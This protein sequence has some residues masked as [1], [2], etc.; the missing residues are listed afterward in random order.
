MTPR[1]KTKIA[2]D[3]N[4]MSILGVQI[5]FVSGFPPRR[6]HRDRLLALATGRGGD[7]RL[8]ARR[9]HRQLA[10]AQQAQARAQAP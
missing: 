4:R 2:L 7:H 9:Q 6:T 1:K 10:R 5:A 3:E 8:E